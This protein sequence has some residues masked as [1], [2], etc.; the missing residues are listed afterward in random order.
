LEAEKSTPFFGAE[1]RIL[2]CKSCECKLLKLLM[3]DEET[4]KFWQG[5]AQDNAQG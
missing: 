2:L 4:M 5:F 3:L 1:R